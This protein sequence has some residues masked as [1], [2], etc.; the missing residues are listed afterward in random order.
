MSDDDAAEA[1]HVLR[2]AALQARDDER[3][4]SPGGIIGSGLTTQ[5]N[6]YTAAAVGSESRD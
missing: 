3:L 4:E 1:V 2:L 5:G 6:G